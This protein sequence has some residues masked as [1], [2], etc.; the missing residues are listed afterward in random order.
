M[1]ASNGDLYFVL[2]VGNGQVIG[3]SEMYEMKA[4]HF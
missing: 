4:G 3:T 1:K 2:K